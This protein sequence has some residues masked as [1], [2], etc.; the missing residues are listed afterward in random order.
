MSQRYREAGLQEEV[1]NRHEDKR[2]LERETG[3]RH[4]RTHFGENSAAADRYYETPNPVR[5]QPVAI[6]G[7]DGKLKII[8]P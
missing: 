1:I 6:M 2:A 4:E 7:R 5:R 8:K 3:L